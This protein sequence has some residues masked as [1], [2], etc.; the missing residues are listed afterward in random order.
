MAKVLIDYDAVDGTLENIDS[1]SSVSLL[2][3][4]VLYIEE[5]EGTEHYLNIYRTKLVTS[6]PK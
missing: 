6:I 4:G 1:V 5:E 3:G 2:D